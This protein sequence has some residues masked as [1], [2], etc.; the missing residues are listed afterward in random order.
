[1]LSESQC[2]QIVTMFSF[3]K[4][5]CDPFKAK[6]CSKKI[7]KMTP[8]VKTKLENMN[9]EGVESAICSTCQIK[10]SKYTTSTKM[11]MSAEAELGACSLVVDDQKHSDYMSESESDID[12][13]DF[14]FKNNRKE[15]IALLNDTV[16][17]MCNLSPISTKKLSTKYIAGKIQEVSLGLKKKLLGSTYCQVNEAEVKARD[18]DVLLSELRTKFAEA[19]TKNEKYQILTLLPKSWTVSK[20]CKE[21]DCTVYMAKSAK[22]LHETNGILSM[23]ASKLPS[24]KVDIA[25]ANL[26]N[27]FYLQDDISRI[28]PGKKDCISMLVNGK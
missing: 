15:F 6:K 19:K 20:M 4:K 24:N 16:A 21:F 2:C 9:I 3:K 27:N 28:M 18:F 25:T 23:P 12:C 5:C 26:V 17:P 7:L 10:V 14:D 11:D 1:M 13:A 22:T 8:S